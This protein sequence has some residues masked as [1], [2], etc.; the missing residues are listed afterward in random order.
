M[1]S[2]WKTT[3]DLPRKP[4]LTENLKTEV[5][6]VGGGM[7]GIL[8]AYLLKKQG[9]D[10]TVLEANTIASGQTGNTT[11]KITSQ[12]GY[13]YDKLC[14]SLGATRAG[15]YAMANQTAI[16]QYQKI[17][18]EEGIECGFEKC[19]AYLYSTEETA[20]LQREAR[21]AAGLGIPATFTT[22]SELPF[23]VAGAVRFENQA[24]FHPLLFLKALLDGLN[25]YEHTPVQL[26]EGGRL[27]AAK[28]RVSAKH[29]VFACHYP[30]INVPGYYFL[31][32]HQERSYVLALENAARLSGM[33]I[34]MDSKGY[35]FRNYGNLLLLG[36]ENHRTGKNCE[37]IRYASLEKT[38]K[39]FYPDCFEA[40]RW[41]AQDCMTLDA[42]PYI[43]RFS[44]AK[45]H[46]YIATGF[47]KWGMTSS[48]V[49]ATILSEKIAGKDSAYTEVFSP[50]R[51][52]FGLSLPNLLTEIGTA[53]T[54]L[55][56]Q[57]FYIPAET[58]EE[59]SSG[60][61]GVVRMGGHKRGVYRD[62]EGT[63][64]SV[65]TRCPHLGCQLSW[66]PDEQSW[67][68]PCHGSRF[69]SDGKLING[70][71]QEGLPHA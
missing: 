24:Q 12:H 26:G 34:S 36:G 58:A 41:S 60:R 22:D 55:T 53:V 5:A 63:T 25:I 42:I 9:A 32:M 8:T 68:C 6:V 43:G 48:M 20:P 21:A 51:F 14:S 52:N 71:A 44:A 28:H 31:R 40:F 54:N 45:P 1:Q 69:D 66:N 7:A 70:P 61:G 17:V 64:H 3:A 46:W 62:K 47:N 2:L 67:D 35:S 15:E 50:Q 65:T 18:E 30:F 27:Y 37:N 29:V 39:Q 33:Y 4:I 38:A 59:L 23:P 57:L 10:V 11:A 13:I 49:S 56:K 16:L 19:P